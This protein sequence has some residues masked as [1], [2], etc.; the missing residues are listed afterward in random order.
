MTETQ[1]AELR[2][3]Q[4]A[5]DALGVHI[6]RQSQAG[7]SDVELR[8]LSAAVFALQKAMVAFVN[9]LATTR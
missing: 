9:D 8:A 1:R 4:R 6:A 5:T 3:M 2:G 7:A